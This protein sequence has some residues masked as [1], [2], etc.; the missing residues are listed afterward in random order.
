MLECSQGRG[1]EANAVVKKI[2]KKFKG[3][4]REK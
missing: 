2:A 4:H 3:V 1:K